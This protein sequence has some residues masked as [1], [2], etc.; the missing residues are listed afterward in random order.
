M[1]AHASE[2]AIEHRAL[3]GSGPVLGDVSGPHVVGQGVQRRPCH[4][5][6]PPP[7]LELFENVPPDAH[8]VVAPIPA[9]LQEGLQGRFQVGQPTSE[10]CIRAAAAQW[11]S[12]SKPS[13]RTCGSD[14]GGGARSHPR[15]AQNWDSHL[16]VPWRG[17]GAGD[18]PEATNLA[19][20]AM[21]RRPRSREATPQCQP[22]PTMR[23]ASWRRPRPCGRR[24]CRGT[25]HELSPLGYG[26]VELQAAQVEGVGRGP[27]CCQP[28]PIRLSA[29]SVC[30]GRGQAGPVDAARARDPAEV[31][32]TPAA[33]PGRPTTP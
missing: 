2:Q 12:S 24:R 21:T 25:R 15:R 33:L 14:R 26:R 8:Q 10:S 16:I 17:A 5:R 20:V 29:R 22:F 11:L 3:K 32:Q 18:V 1:V 19:H 9:E 7:S 4:Q 28:E 23:C 27:D 31:G 30:R 6:R 13:P